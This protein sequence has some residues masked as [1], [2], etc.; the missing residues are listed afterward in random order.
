MSERSATAVAHIARES[1]LLVERDRARREFRQ[2]QVKPFVDHAN[3]RFAP[4]TVARL[5]QRRM[6]TLRNSRVPGSRSS[7]RGFSQT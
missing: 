3:G 2:R 1:Q 4:Y 5:S 6:A 7:M